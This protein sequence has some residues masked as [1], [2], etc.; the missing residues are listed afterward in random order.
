[1]NTLA[2]LHGLRFIDSFFP[3]GGYAF[4]SGLEAAVQDGAVR[5]A[6]ELSRYVEDYLRGSAGTRDVIALGL[7][8]GAAENGSLSEAL[9]ADRL[10]EAMSISR[11]TRFASRQMGRQVIRV[12]GEQFAGNALVKG[13]LAE[14]ETGRSPGHLAVCLGLVL[15]VLGWT[16]QEAAA[17][18]LYQC[19]VGFVSAALKLLPIGQREAQR[20]LAQVVPLIEKLSDEAGSLH[21][22]TSW[23]PVQEIYSMRHSRLRTR[24]F[25]S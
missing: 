5:D 24:L 14:V 12:A 23:A 17:A 22:M 6:E 25:R 1:M 8:H 3:S 13:Y 18:F 10:L 21:E 2:F 11:E 20:R 7:A 16:R 19:T 4:S 15:G 9:E